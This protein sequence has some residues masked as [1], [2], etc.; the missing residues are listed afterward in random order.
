M[1]STRTFIGIDGCPAGWFCVILDDRDHWSFRLAPDEHGVGELATGADSVLIDIPIGLCDSG[2]DGRDCDR[3]ARRLLGRGRASSVFSAPARRT[4]A[5]TGYADALIRNR[6]ATGRG[7]SRQAW[8][9]VP[10]IR[11]IDALL[12]DQ[13]ALCGVLRECHPELCFW[14]LNGRHAMQFN[15]KQGQ[16]QQ[17]RLAVLERYFPQCHA[18][19]EQASENCLRRQVAHD[20]I[21]DA[22]VCAVTAKLG[23]GG[24]QTVPARPPRDGQGLSME[25]VYCELETGSGSK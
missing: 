23:H 19:F 25:I 3:E 17:E 22:M 21:V 12:R 16:G 2:S 1:A 7:L 5:A 13:R 6:Q 24:Y 10:K 4:L 20:D 14:A 18:L 9:I 15:K 8:G 11:A